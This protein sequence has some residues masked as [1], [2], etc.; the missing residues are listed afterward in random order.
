MKKNLF[1]GMVAVAL[2]SCSS[3]DLV[4][5][6]GP[7]SE[8]SQNVA[9]GFNVSKQNMTRSTTALN[10]LGHYNFGVWAYKSNAGAGATEVMNHYLVGFS[11]ATNNKGY[12]VGPLTTTF[13]ANTPNT[14]DYKS[15]WFYEGLGNTEYD[16]EGTDGYYKKTETDYMSENEKQYLRYWDLAYTNTDFY[17]YAPYN[18]AVTFD[19]SSKTMTLPN[20]VL[21][22]GYDAPQNTDYTGKIH[23]LGD[24]MYAGVRA[25]N[26][27]LN[28]VTIPFKRVGAQ[29]FIRFYENIPGYRVE[30]VDLNAD[31]GTIKDGT[32][33]KYKEGIQ[34]TPA[35]GVVSPS[36]GSYANK[37]KATVAF[38]FSANPVE[39]FTPDYAGTTASQENLM[40]KVPTSAAPSA[41][42]TDIHSLTSWEGHNVIEQQV[43]SGTQKWSYSPTVYYPVAQ[44]QTSSGTGFTFH[45]TYRIIAED[46]KE[47]ITVH[48]A[49]VHVPATDG[50][51]PATSIARWQNNTRY[52]YTFLITKNTTGTT[53]PGGEINPRDPDPKTSEK[54]LYPIVFD[55]ATLE[56]F[57]ELEKEYNIND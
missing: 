25:I 56:D 50:G 53:N 9:I 11:D 41:L 29:V 45:V 19:A 8:S 7:N 26:A 36:L 34:A 2:A 27:N 5:N 6:S 28:D 44:D 54:A 21:T 30:I 49:K 33:D 47:V 38:D 32:A 17:C 31:G 3:H 48:N 37:Y 23:N 55:G 42:P 1:F 4:D 15:P 40:F 22:D 39:T 12:K 51:T 14:S 24:F 46:N 18:S 52:T 35:T 10:A 20:S 13:I 57:T 16:Y 43:T